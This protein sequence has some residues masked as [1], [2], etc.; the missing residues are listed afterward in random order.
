MTILRWG[1]P[2]S[3]N[4]AGGHKVT[5]G[6]HAAVTCGGHVNIFDVYSYLLGDNCRSFVDLVSITYSKV[7][8]NLCLKLFFRPT[9]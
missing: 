1:L 9:N 5:V 4:L 3:V 6:H 2:K 8:I 7:T